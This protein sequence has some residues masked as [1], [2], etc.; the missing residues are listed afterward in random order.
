MTHEQKKCVACGK[1]TSTRGPMKG[2]P[3]CSTRCRH[4]R[5]A[6]QGRVVDEQ[7]QPIALAEEARQQQ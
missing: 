6:S 5:W 1:P 3:F 4:K 2:D 7:G